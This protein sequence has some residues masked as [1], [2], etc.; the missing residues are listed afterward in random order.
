M[1][2]GLKKIVNG[3]CAGVML[4]GITWSGQAVNVEWKEG[5][6]SENI[7][8]IVSSDPIWPDN[9]PVWPDG[10]TE[11]VDPI[12]PDSPQNPDE[13]PVWPDENASTKSDPIWPD[14]ERYSL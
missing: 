8:F 2:R 4:V 5:G 14:D 3:V 6:A 7:S 10:T 12:W 1:V 9:D 13:D 11:S